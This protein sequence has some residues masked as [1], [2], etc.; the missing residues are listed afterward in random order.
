[1]FLLCEQTGFIKDTLPPAF[2]SKRWAWAEQT[3]QA[4]GSIATIPIAAMLAILRPLILFAKFP[5]M[6]KRR[7]WVPSS[8]DECSSHVILSTVA[9]TVPKMFEVLRCLGGDH[10][11][12]Q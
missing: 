8:L 2:Q 7:C 1:M 10:R 5:N 6:R 11:E 12:D 9:F 3:I 4:Y